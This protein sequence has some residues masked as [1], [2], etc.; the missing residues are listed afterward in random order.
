MEVG[1]AKRRAVLTYCD[2]TPESRNNGVAR[3]S[4]TVSS[5]VF[6]AVRAEVIQR[7]LL[8]SMTNE[9]RAMI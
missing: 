8:P 9:L 6:Y 7:G 4:I 1:T 3:N 2:M 5:G